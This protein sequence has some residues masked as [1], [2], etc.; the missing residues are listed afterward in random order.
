MSYL[1]LAYPKI[2]KSDFDFIQDYR[3]A[4]DPKYFLLVEPHFTI[5]FSR[6]FSSR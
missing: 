2:S 4:N 5:V 1:V 3:K 6:I